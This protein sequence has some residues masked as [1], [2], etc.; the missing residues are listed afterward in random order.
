MST[1]NPYVP[2]SGLPPHLPP[3]AAP[4]P[5]STLDFGR[6]FGFFF[7]DPN[8][9]QKLL[10]GSLFSLL[11]MFLI[12][13]IFVAGYAARLVRRT[14]RGEPYPLPEWEDFGGMFAEGLSV[15]GAYLL[16]VAPAV[17]VTAVVFIPLAVLG[18]RNGE[19]SPA[20]VFLLIP[21]VLLATLVLLGILVYFPAVFIRVA[22]EERFSAAFEFE[23]NW[24]FIKRNATNYL[25]AIAAFIVANFIAQFGILLFCI[26]ILPA[27]FW[28]QCA[29]AY[30]LGEVA[31]RDPGRAASGPPPL[32]V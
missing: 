6:A 26:G 4:R 2:P 11:S 3:A 8:W 7:Q 17:I 14:A 27:T 12:G 18:E 19:P 24:A 29:G 22:V 23:N 1:I 25:L 30:A 5:G 32:H 21:I 13:A 15:V 16:H 31:L 20:A 10:I 28:C 9:V